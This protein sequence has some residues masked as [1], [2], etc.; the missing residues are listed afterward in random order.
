MHVLFLLIPYFHVKPQVPKVVSDVDT[1]PLS[2]HHL[3]HHPIY[4]DGMRKHHTQSV[5]LLPFGAYTYYY[6]LTTQAH[7]TD[8]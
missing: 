5:G 6:M 1:Q 2:F 3:F 4:A 8:V 7:P